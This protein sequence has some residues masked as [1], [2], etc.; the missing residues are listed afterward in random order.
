MNKSN[1][2]FIVSI[3]IL[4]ILFI[5][6]YFKFNVY[7]VTFVVDNEIY[8]TVEV[9]KDTKLDN[10]E[11]PTKDGYAFIGWYDEDNNV[12]ESDQ[13]ITKDVVYY[14]RWATIVTD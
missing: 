14:A 9:R 11:V 13:K 1:V 8:Q 2:F 3:V 12:F 10:I 6:V 7:K 5:T 4:L